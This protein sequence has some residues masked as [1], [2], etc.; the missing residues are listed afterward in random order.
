MDKMSFGQKL[1]PSLT[2]SLI[3]I[4][5]QTNLRKIGKNHRRIEPGRAR[6]KQ[7]VLKFKKLRFSKMLWNAIEAKPKILN[8][9]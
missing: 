5:H 6:T 2:L 3:H 4:S 9:G 1:H 8:T 7:R